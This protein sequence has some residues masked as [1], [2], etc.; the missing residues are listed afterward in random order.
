[1]TFYTSIAPFYDQIFPYQP[2]QKDFIDSFDAGGQEA[3][4]LDVGCGTGSLALN[5]A[6][7][8]GTVVGIDPDKEMLEKANLKALP[9]KMKHQTELEQLGKWVFMPLG[10]SDLRSEFA[11]GS[12]DM[13]L[14]LGNTLVH[15]ANLQEV[16]AFLHDTL[17]VLKTG[18]RLLIQIINY[19]RI[20]SQQL[21]GLPTIENDQIRFERSYSYPDDPDT[22]QFITRLTV[23]E[24]N[25]VIEN[26]VPLL[27]LRHERLEA[28][29]HDSGYRDVQTFGNFKGEPFTPESQPFIVS[30]TK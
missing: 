16:T 4:L 30:A 14:C 9:F 17:Y 27:A 28:Y 29:L 23:K 3:T 11:P 8:F 18:G 19:D 15:L 25:Q 21:P 1:M 24:S 12:F 6:E 26:Q 13:V 10:M 7:S 2:Q 22:V 20:I 5:L